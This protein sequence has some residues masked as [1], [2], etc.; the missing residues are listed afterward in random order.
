MTKHLILMII[1]ICITIGIIMLASG[2]INKFLNNYPTLQML[3]LSFL[4]LIGFMLIPESID[5]QVAKVYLY[6][7]VLFSL[8]V[9]FLNIQLRKIQK[10]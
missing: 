3:A 2:S 6:F 5:M 7:A 9:E 8:F 1:A 10:I 4:T